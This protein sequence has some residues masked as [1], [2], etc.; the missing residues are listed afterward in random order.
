MESLQTKNQIFFKGLLRKLKCNENYYN[1]YTNEFCLIDVSE[2]G[3]KTSE[4][5]KIK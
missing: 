4:I 1:M 5:L 3:C 2:R